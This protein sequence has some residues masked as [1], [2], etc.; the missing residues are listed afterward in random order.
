MQLKPWC[1]GAGSVQERLLLCVADNEPHDTEHS[2]QFDQVVY[3]PSTGS[4]KISKQEMG[5][6]NA[7]PN[8]KYEH[9]F[10]R[11]E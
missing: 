9:F 10:L 11:T 6:S 2:V 8:R 1:N 7:S 5:R 4:T 3:L